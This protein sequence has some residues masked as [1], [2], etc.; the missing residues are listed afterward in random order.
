VPL[1][2]VSPTTPYW[3]LS[4]LLLVRGI[5]T[6][7]SFMPAMAAVYAVLDRSQLPD[8]APQMNLLHRIGQASGTAFLAVILA[9]QLAGP[10]E[11]AE[12][13]GRTFLFGLGFNV[14]GLVPAFA[15][16]VIDRRRYAAAAARTAA[17]IPA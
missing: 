16:A 1:V 15:L 10:A 14:L 2:F 7:A 6:G 13:F 9:E 17:R 8:A 4:T 12:A 5:G 11:V 3:W